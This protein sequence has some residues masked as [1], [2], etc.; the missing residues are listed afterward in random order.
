MAFLSRSLLL[1]GC[2]FI[3]LPLPALALSWNWSFVRSAG[4]DGPAVMASGEL[5]TTDTPDPSGF[6]TINSVTGTRN[7]VSISALLA[8]GSVA[9]GN[10][11]D[12]M[13]CY[14]SD[15]LLSA[16][17]GGAPQ[18]TSHGFNVAFA[19]GTYANYFFASFLS[20]PTDLEFYSTPPF[21]F[22]PPGGP[23]SP[24]SELKGV[25][26]ATPVPGPLPA[27]GALIGLKW[28]RRLRRSASNRQ[29]PRGRLV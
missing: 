11:Y 4:A 1:L 19:D 10:C 16:P 23:V 28:A 29:T 15:N 6:Y 24:D 2:T 9:P 12:A 17:S 8:V 7:S 25:F 18:L 21:D 26:Q 5:I 14:A 22:I 20:P 13:T 27:A 3:T